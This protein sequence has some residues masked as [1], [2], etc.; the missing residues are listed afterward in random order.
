MHQK[1]HGKL[2]DNNEPEVTKPQKK[3]KKKE[4]KRKKHLQ[5]LYIITCFELNSV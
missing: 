2:T 4:K 1:H 3:F 5:K